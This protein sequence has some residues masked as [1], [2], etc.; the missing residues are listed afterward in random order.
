[1]QKKLVYVNPQSYRNLSVYD[2]SLLKGIEDYKIIYC[3]NKQY[4]G[5]E[6]DNV[7]FMP[8]FNYR[9][10]MTPVAKILSYLC[11]LFR[12][13]FILKVEKPDVMHIQWW[14]QWNVDFFFLSLYKKFVGQVVYTAHNLV[15][16]NTGERMKAKCI[17]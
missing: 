13:V 11:S 12:L 2:Y 6:L 8:I 5:P 15:P 1:M 3:C 14:K 4:D 17:M 7:K 16:H 9:Q 10:N